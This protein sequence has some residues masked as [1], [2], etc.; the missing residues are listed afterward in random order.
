MAGMGVDAPSLILAISLL[1]T[2]CKIPREN[3]FD[4][5][6]LTL[7]ALIIEVLFG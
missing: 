3:P 5:F 1:V 4:V 7:T 2:L 6:P